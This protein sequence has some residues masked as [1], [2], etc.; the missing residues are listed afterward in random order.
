MNFDFESDGAY[1]LAL[2]NLSIYDYIDMN[3]SQVEFSLCDDSS[4]DEGVSCT[5][6]MSCSAIDCANLM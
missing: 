1:D 6:T 5:S 3:L 2:T 4:Y